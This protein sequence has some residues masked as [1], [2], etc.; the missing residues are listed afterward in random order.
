MGQIFSR[1]PQ[2]ASLVEN[3][4]PL[5]NYVGEVDQ[6]GK[7][8]YTQ[9]DPVSPSMA[10]DFSVSEL[11]LMGRESVSPMRIVTDPVDLPNVV[12]F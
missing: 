1:A 8:V 12:E 6:N 9:K 3:P 5:K 11:A 2:R 4:N 10:E 7:I